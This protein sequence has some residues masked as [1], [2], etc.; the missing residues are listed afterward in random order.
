[1]PMPQF[2]RTLENRFPNQANRAYVSAFKPVPD[3]TPCAASIGQST[4]GVWLIGSGSRPWRARI[5]KACCG[6]PRLKVLHGLFTLLL[7]T[8]LAGA[9][10]SRRISFRNDVMAVLSKAG[11]NAG[12]CHGN[13][14]GKAGFKLSLRGQDPHGDYNA[15]T[16][17][18]LGRR[19]DPEAA[20]QSLILL[21]PT[22][23]IAHE[24]GQRFKPDSEE[25]A[26]L[27]RWIA[28]GM[29]FDPPNTPML[30]C[31][32]VAPIEKIL[33]EPSNEIQL[34]A[35][36]FFSDGS[37]REVTRMA[38]YDAA[39]GVAKVTHDGLVQRLSPGETTVLVRYL[40]AQVPVRLAFMPARPGFVWANPPA[41]NYIDEEVFAKLRMLRINPSD[42][43]SDN[44][45]IRRAY[46]DLL[47]ILP[48]AEE[49]RAFVNESPNGEAMMK[50]P[51][52]KAGR[53]KDRPHPGPLL[54]ERGKHAQRPGIFTFSGGDAFDGD[55]RR[56]LQK[57]ARL[58]DQLLD[59]PEFADFWALKWADLLRAEERLLDRKGIETFQRWIRRSIEE[60]KPLDQF[61][62]ELI[63]AR[64]S[65]YF[66]P[67]SNFYRAVR[68]PVARAE[69]VAQVFL[70]TQLRCA[71]CHNHPFDKW[72]QDDYYD[73]ADVFARLNYKVLEN[74]RRDSNDGHEF[75]GEQIVYVATKG[76][77]KNPRSGKAAHPRFLGESSPMTLAQDESSSGPTFGPSN[78]GERIQ[79]PSN[80][81]PLRAFAARHSAAPA[82]RRPGGVRSGLDELDALA[83]WVTS[84]ENPFFAR[85][86]VNRVWFHL[87]GRG[88]VDPI[89]DFRATNPPSHP[90]LL[91]LLAA[92]FVKHKF[93]LRHVIRL[94]M[95]SRAYQLS[96]MPNDLN[97]DD[98]LNFSR[99][100]V[101]R[102]TAEQ[103]LD[104]QSAVIGVPVKFNG[105]PLGLRAAQL[106]GALPERKRDQK[107][108]E[109]DHFL[110]TFGK[111]ARLLTCECERSGDTTM[112]QAFQ[113][114]SGQAI[115]DLLAAPDNRLAQLLASR[116]STREIVEELYWTALT[117]PPTEKEANRATSL[118]NE[119]KNKRRA[120][121]DL[122]W[123]LLNAKEF[124]LRK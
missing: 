9:E 45:F 53:G 27:R 58:I 114:I 83:D 117:R 44:E 39:N 23:Q 10:P 36:A 92:D 26:I 72:T 32:E 22:T 57:R 2:S 90:A 115:N 41:N 80:E 85:A 121:E 98:D 48:S 88:I 94:I 46:L 56:R 15:L 95:N 73:W 31:L 5:A 8:S 93:D 21:K 67:A 63:A 89:D 110:E 37:D 33:F 25:Y 55:L 34:R 3:M 119:S 86:Q 52:E 112:G 102:L 104:C 6:K 13:A 30:E 124:V 118:L 70:G 71:Q 76:E 29:P 108:S 116:K 24:G 101:R 91:D 64:G 18:M 107:M 51:S 122:T 103:L 49:A 19:T 20:D 66:N 74:R 65:T 96:A 77:V 40:H 75:K 99:A 120:L 47:G 61:A 60:N 12:Q 106:P 4:D 113:M 7:A 82:R 59:R 62:R 105:Y 14:N 54:Q 11:C 109:V 100:Y 84:P 81:V 79:P 123:A 1:M 28:E 50:S 17:D 42:L 87:M 16:R 35:R 78:G 38:V 97:R 43:C 69:A 111:P 68:E